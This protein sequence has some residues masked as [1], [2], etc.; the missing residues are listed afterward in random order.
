MTLETLLVAVIVLIALLVV[1]RHLK[2]KFSARG[3]KP[4]N[5][6]CG[7]CVKEFKNS[8]GRR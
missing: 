2:K 5:E 7:E 8:R 3:S 6:G 4:C 1:L